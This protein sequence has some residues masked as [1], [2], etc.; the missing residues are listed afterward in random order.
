MTLFPPSGGEPAIIFM[1]AVPANAVFDAAGARLFE[2]PMT[3][4]RIIQALE[5][6]TAGRSERRKVPE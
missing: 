1:G 6:R 2:L 5:P 3:P 4:G